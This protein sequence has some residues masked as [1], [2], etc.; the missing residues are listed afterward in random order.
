MDKK[1]RRNPIDNPTVFDRLID[2]SSIEPKGELRFEDLA[3]MMKIQRTHPHFYVILDYLISK[4]IL[5]ITN[6]YGNIK[7][8]RLNNDKL[9]LLLYE[10]K[11]GQ[12]LITWLKR[13]GNFM[14]ET[15]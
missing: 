3:R 12:K 6:Q 2:L 10:S 15:S 14:V 7:I 9:Y 8:F 1:E 4:E 5:T 11:K 13:H